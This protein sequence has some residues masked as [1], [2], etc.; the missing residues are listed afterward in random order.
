MEIRVR[1]FRHVVVED[2]VHSLD[3]HSSTEE[4]RRHENTRLKFFEFFVTSQTREK[5]IDEEKIAERETHRA[6]CSM[7][8][9]IS[10]AGKFCSVSNL[11]RAV[12]RGTDLTKITT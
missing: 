4:I 8:R 6:S 9:W 7:P 12:Q 2:D 11:H 3:V 5:Q 10:T 1:A